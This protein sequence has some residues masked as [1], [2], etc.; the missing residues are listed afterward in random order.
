MSKPTP[1]VAILKRVKELDAKLQDPRLT[2]ERIEYLQQQRRG[3]SKRLLE[4]L[5]HENS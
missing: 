3:L 1:S 5:R 4:D 2:M